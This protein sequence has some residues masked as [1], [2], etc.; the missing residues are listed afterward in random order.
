MPLGLPTRVLRR[1]VNLTRLWELP[2]TPIG[3]TGEAEGA[4][5][6]ERHAPRSQAIGPDRPRILALQVQA[7]VV[8]MVQKRSS[9]ARTAH[10]WHFP[11]TG[12]GSPQSVEQVDLTDCPLGD[13]GLGSE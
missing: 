11:P 5:R 10:E 2:I 4:A 8:V 1:A 7:L 9:M 12:A 3:L 6:P 13:G